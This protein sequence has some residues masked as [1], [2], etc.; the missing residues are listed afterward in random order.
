MRTF[1]TYIEYLLM[2]RHYCYV[3]GHGAYMFS[4]EPA[5]LGS[6]P[7]IGAD[8][9]RVHTLT[10]PRRVVRFSPLLTHDD[11]LLANLLMEAEGM[12]YDDATG[13]IARQVATLTADSLVDTISLDTDTEHFGFTPLHLETWT[14]IEQ[15]LKATD[16]TDSQEGDSEAAAGKAAASSTRLEITREHVSIPMPWVRRA[17]ACLLIAVFFFT[18]FIGLNQGNGNLASMLDVSALQ[19][20]TLVHQSWDASDE[21]YLSDPTLDTLSLDDSELLA[22]ASASEDV[23][24]VD[25]ATVPVE[26]PAIAETP[27]SMKTPAEPEAPVITEVAPVSPASATTYYII[28][29]ST[30]SSTYA[31]QV[32]NRYH[33]EGY[34]HVGVLERDGRYRLFIGSYADRQEAVTHLREVRQQSEKLSHAWMLTVEEGSLSYIIKDKYNDNQLSME[35]SHPNTGPERDQG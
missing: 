17:A 12:S 7:S 3:P 18:N 19:R 27:A 25:D 10:A 32:C 15:R 6:V 1:V 9:R 11:G 26:T 20:S 29:A 30:T 5:D 24:V 23:S 28:I 8:S 13:Y 21:E 14:D 22:D 16:H 33:R 31:Q 35:L 2:T 34:E 4:D